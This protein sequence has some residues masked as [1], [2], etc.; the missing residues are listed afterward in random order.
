MRKSPQI[1]LIGFWFFNSIERYHTEE[2]TDTYCLMILSQSVK[3]NWNLQEGPSEQAC[4]KA[5]FF[6]F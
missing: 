1:I 4:Y 5:L 6:L 3:L 2:F